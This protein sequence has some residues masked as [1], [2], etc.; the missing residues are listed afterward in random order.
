MINFQN[1]K[2]ISTLDGSSTVKLSE[3]EECFHSVNGALNESIHIFI[4][5][6]LLYK[7]NALT[8][9][10]IIEVGMGTGLN[11]LL[12]IREAI[13]RKLAINYTAYELYPLTLSEAS[14]LNYNTIV[15]FPGCNEFLK[16][17]HETAFNKAINIGNNFK[18]LKKQEDVCSADFLGNA[19]DL[20]YFD[21]FS[22][23]IQPELWSQNIFSKIYESSAPNAALLTYSSKGTVKR[24]LKAAGFMVEKLPGPTGKREIIR[25]IKK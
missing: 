18:L 11:V 19:F 13:N 3:S 20:I 16:L 22:P 17:I 5:N 21:A 8:K 23:A 4:N 7:V 15:N 10:N 6:G 1:R 9:I 14:K 12:T 25:A 2:I 24:A